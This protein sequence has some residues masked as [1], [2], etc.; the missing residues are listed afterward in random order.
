MVYGGDV[1]MNLTMY[2][3]GGH[4]RGDHGS[5]RMTVNLTLYRSGGRP[6]IWWSS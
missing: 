6:G 4:L 3:Y 2:T 5:V 1:I